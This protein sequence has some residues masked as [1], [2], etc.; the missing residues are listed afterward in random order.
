MFPLAFGELYSLSVLADAHQTT[1]DPSTILASVAWTIM[2]LTTA[3]VVGDSSSDEPDELDEPET[4][5]GVAPEP[6]GGA[7]A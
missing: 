4:K 1:G 7:A 3:G 5:S 6:D 2:A